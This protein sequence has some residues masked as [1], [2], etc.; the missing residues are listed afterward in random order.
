[1]FSTYKEAKERE[2]TRLEHQREISRQSSARY[3][4]KHKDDKKLWSTKLALE[5]L[6]TYAK[7]EK[8]PQ[9]EGY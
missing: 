2:E 5:K 1:M 3:Y 9:Y 6:H 7:K 4:K 8:E